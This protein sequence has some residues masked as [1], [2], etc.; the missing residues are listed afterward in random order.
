MDK[1]AIKAD[2][3]YGVAEVIFTKMDGTVRKMRATLASEYLPKTIEEDKKEAD[4]EKE[5]SNPN[6]VAVWDLDNKGWR[7]FRVDR[8]ISMQRVNTI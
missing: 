8:V 3:K 1:E 4:F 2:L 7:S 6:V 5:D